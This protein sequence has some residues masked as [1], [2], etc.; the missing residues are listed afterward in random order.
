MNTNKY[1]L[2]IFLKVYKTFEPIKP[3]YIQRPTG[4][5]PEQNQFRLQEHQSESY[6]QLLMESE[7]IPLI[8]EIIQYAKKTIEIDIYLKA[9]FISFQMISKG[10]YD[11]WN[12]EL[13]PSS[14]EPNTESSNEN[15]NNLE[16]VCKVKRNP[17]ECSVNLYTKGGCD[18][19]LYKV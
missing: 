9:K 3:A 17:K 2:I 14:I 8:A 5:I 13:N 18:I 11:V 7:K 12:K 10:Q 16:S 15:I 6:K 19:C 1:Y 4:V